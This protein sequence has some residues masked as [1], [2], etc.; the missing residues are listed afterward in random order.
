MNTMFYCIRNVKFCI[1][2][3]VVFITRS[4]EDATQLEYNEASD[5]SKN[6]LHIGQR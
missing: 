4:K 6:N 3:F 1:T 5:Y 2:Y